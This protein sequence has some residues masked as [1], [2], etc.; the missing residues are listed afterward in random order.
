MSA[1]GQPITTF[2]GTWT[3]ISG[4]GRYEGV[5][6]RGRYK[7]RVVSPTEYVIEWDGELNLKGNTATR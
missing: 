7:G 6:G 1:D 2:E 5:T 4:S 3:K